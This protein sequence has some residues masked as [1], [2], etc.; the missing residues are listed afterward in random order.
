MQVQY[1]DDASPNCFCGCVIKKSVLCYGSL[2][3]FGVNCSVLPTVHTC[4]GWV[5]KSQSTM[6]KRTYSLYRSLNQNSLLVKDFYSFQQISFQGRGDCWLQVRVAC[7]PLA[8]GWGGQLPL[9]PSYG[10][11]GGWV[12]YWNALQCIVVHWGLIQIAVWLHQKV[13]CNAVCIIV[14]L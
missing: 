1:Q 12:L 13:Q 3:W 10:R 2:P 5:M 4:M 11:E 14:A 8:G 7:V 9:R 6:S